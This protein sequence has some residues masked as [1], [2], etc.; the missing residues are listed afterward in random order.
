MKLN[1]DNGGT[2]VADCGA[3]KDTL[4]SAINGMLATTWTPMSETMVEAWYYFTG[5]DIGDKGNPNKRSFY[6]NITYQ[7]PIQYYCQKNY[8]F[9]Q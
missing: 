8:Y 9:N 2:V 7:T 3:S 6:N 5:G 1:S 4:L